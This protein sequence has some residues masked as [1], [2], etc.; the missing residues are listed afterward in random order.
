MSQG[1]CFHCHEPIPDGLELTVEILNKPRSMCCL[2]C[3]AVAESIVEAG[4]TDYYKHRTDVAGK[5]EGDLVPDALKLQFERLDMAEIQDEFCTTEGNSKEALLSLDGVRCAA[6]AWLI[7]KHLSRQAG[8]VRA[9]VNSSTHRLLLRWDPA[10]AAL[11]KLLKSLAE[12][13]YQA[14]PYDKEV[15]DKSY[16]DKKQSFLIRIGVSALASMQVMMFAVALYFGVFDMEPHQQSYLRWVSLLMAT[17]VIC[18]AAWPFY[19]SAI[20]SIKARHPNMDVPVS[21]ALILAFIASSYA[22]IYQTGEV[23][24]ESISMFT[25]FLLL[26][27][28]A[29]LVARHRGNARSANA[30]KLLPAVVHRLT[31]Y[32]VE[33]VP[34]KQILAGQRLLLKPGET[35]AV[36]GVIVKGASHVDL[37]VLT[38]E[39]EPIAKTVGDTVFAG[40]INQ[41]QPLEIEVT[42]VKD[43]MVASIVRMQEQA[44]ASRAKPVQFADKVAR[45]FVI[46]LLIVASATATFWYFN[47]PEDALWI[48]LA[49]LVATCPC[50]LSLATPTA[51]TAGI[52]RL[53]ASGVIAKTAD[54]LDQLASIDRIAFDKTG[55]LTHGTLSVNDVACYSDD[56]DTQQALALAAS[57]EAGANHPLADAIV[58]AAAANQSR[59]LVANNIQ[60]M[61]GFGVCGEVNGQRFYLGSPQYIEQQHAG[62]APSHRVLLANEQQVLAGFDFIDPPRSDAAQLIKQ[63]QQLGVSTAVVSGDQQTHT[64]TLADKLAISDAVGNCTP[65]DKLAWV[66]QKQANGEAVLMVGDGIN[67]GPVLSQANASIAIS[68]GTDIAKRSADAVLLGSK[69]IP[70]ATAIR[71]GQQTK[72][73]IRQNLAWALGYN[74]VVLPLAVSGML[75]P[76]IAVIGMSASSLIVVVNAMRIERLKS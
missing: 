62:A 11:S 27:R 15:E 6:C 14:L 58:N 65:E 22:T 38:G 36:D 75:P 7:E 54:L 64:A 63:L 1:S 53:G 18:Y 28:Y 59:V 42:E 21:I 2:G 50:A 74:L 43:T 12:L 72:R 23:Y 26:G 10:Q 8:V 45:Y 70:I 13:G 5:I 48:T 4:L 68:T 3:H 39:H 33:T 44:L 73:I 19:L 29:E 37:S 25:F 66:Q 61:S 76:Y 49:V 60:L 9:T 17:P 20:T 24:F 34:V 32:G 51:I 30:V 57:L 35:L 67:D 47:R 69:L 31:E 71:V 46:A 56:I 16:Q 52:S 55:T 41:E 40:V